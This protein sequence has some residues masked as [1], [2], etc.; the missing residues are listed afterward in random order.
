VEYSILVGL[1]ALGTLL[2]AAFVKVFPIMEVEAGEV[3]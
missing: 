3:A 1:L 2:Y